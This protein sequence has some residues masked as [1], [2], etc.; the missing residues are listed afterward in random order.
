MGSLALGMGFQAG[1]QLWPS[2]VGGVALAA[3]GALG[4]VEWALFLSS[5]SPLEQLI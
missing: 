3:G 5:S 2:V 1:G 4:L